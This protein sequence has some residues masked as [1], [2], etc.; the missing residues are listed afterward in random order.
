MSTLKVN[1]IQ[2]FSGTDINF[3]GNFVP[4]TSSRG[5]SPTLGTEA[6]PWSE[7]YVSTGSVVFVAPGTQ[8]NPQQATVAVLKAGGETA[9]G[10]SQVR[11]M[12]Y[13][14]TNFGLRGSFSVGTNN[15][16]SGTASLATGQYN[17][18]SGNYSHAE[19]NLT[20][21]TGYASHAEGYNVISNGNFSHA[22]GQLTT[23]SG[24][25][26]HAEG[27]LTIASSSHS[28]AEGSNTLA[29][30]G[31]SHA[32]GIYTTAL[33][34]NSHA[35]GYGTLSSGLS[36]HAEG[37]VTIASGDY[38]HAEGSV[39]VASGYASHAGGLYSTASGFY[40]F[41]HGEG[42]Q[43]LNQSKTAVGQ[44]N[45]LNDSSSLFVV[46]VGQSNNRKNGFSVELDNT[47]LA[48]IVIPTNTSN[49]TN[50][51]AG[52]M[53]FNANTNLLYIHN[54]TAWRSSSFA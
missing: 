9:A 8:Q 2:P 4:V 44:W 33:G 19:G 38:S 11:G 37:Y 53:Y 16:A 28:H 43:A 18:A 20:R 42:L 50:P 12:V 46:G 32:E 47:V 17:T 27:Y 54:G 13:T 3:E 31:Q 7:L 24:D 29:L 49:P 6:N 25:Y 52:S 48:H 51:K 15:R 10:F 35:E 26:S 36:S 1:N 39:T 30:G 21:A 34:N 41:A 5:E 40:T 45:V 23:A 22:E 14:E